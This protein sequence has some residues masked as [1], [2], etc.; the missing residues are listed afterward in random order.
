METKICHNRMQQ[1]RRKIGFEGM[2]LVDPVGLSGGIALLWKF[3]DEVIIENYSRHLINATIV[4]GGS[5]E[6]WKLMGFYGHPDRAHRGET[7]NLLSYLK[8]MSPN[9]WL[10]VGYFNEVLDQTEKSG[11]VPRS[12]RQMERFRSVLEE[13]LLGD[14]GFRGSKVT[15]TNCRGVGQFMKER[16]DRATANSAWCGLFREIDEDNR[17]FFGMRLNGPMMR[18]MR[19]LFRDFG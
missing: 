9:P 4:L 1:V 11:G 18:T 12:E 16:L 19:L 14:L 7:R 17:G 5:I 2:L 10:C 15:W 3:A 6:S 13:C 8:G